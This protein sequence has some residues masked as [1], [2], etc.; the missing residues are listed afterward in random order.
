MQDLVEG[1][2]RA[3]PLRHRLYVALSGCKEELED[4]ETSCKEF[5]SPAS[6]FVV[7]GDFISLSLSLLSIISL[8]LGFDWV[9]YSPSYMEDPQLGKTQMDGRGPTI[10]CYRPTFRQLWSSEVCLG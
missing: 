9:H 8:P 5:W 4:F 10:Q 7:L 1:D 3:L 2:S 6:Y